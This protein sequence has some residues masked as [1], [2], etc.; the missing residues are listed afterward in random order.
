MIKQNRSSLSKLAERL[1]ASLSYSVGPDSPATHFVYQSRR[2]KDASREYKTAIDA[3]KLVVHPAWLVACETAGERVHEGA[4]KHTYNETRSLQVLMPQN[5]STNLDS[6]SRRDPSKS[7]HASTTDIPCVAAEDNHSVEG[8]EEDEEFVL[9]P[10]LK[11]ADDHSRASKA[12]ASAV[13]HSTPRAIRSPMPPHS[14]SSKRDRSSSATLPSSQGHDLSDALGD[15]MQDAQPDDS[16]YGTSSDVR[17]PKNKE[18]PE[19]DSDLSSS[20][21]GSKLLQFQERLARSTTAAPSLQ[22]DKTSSPASRT[23]L[24]DMDIPS[25]S[26][27]TRDL[28][29]EMQALMEAEAKL[30]DQMQRHAGRSGRRALGKKVCH[31]RSRHVMYTPFNAVHFFLPGCN[32][33]VLTRTSEIGRLP[34]GWPTGTSAGR[35]QQRL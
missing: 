8:A 21:P 32:T 18:Q 17:I 25:H 24:A 11:R 16:G 2:S 33:F 20:S 23:L 29:A 34:R 14:P 28:M 3:G 13:T 4:F 15:V 7:E 1:G 27:V 26:S 19:A 6:L 35:L 22:A 5:S 10:P 9:P 12:A 30:P 31:P